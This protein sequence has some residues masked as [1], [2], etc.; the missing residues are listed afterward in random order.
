MEELPKIVNDRGHIVGEALKELRIKAQWTQATFEKKSGVSVRRL[1]DIENGKAPIQSAETIRAISDVVEARFPQLKEMGRQPVPSALF[2]NWHGWHWTRDRR[3]H[4]TVIPTVWTIDSAEICEV[5]RPLSKLLYRG[6]VLL[7]EH[8]RLVFT[9]D[10]SS[11]PQERTV[12]RFP[13][14]V[15]EPQELS[16][17]WFGIDYRRQMCCGR[18]VLSREKLTAAAAR[19][20]MAEIPDFVLPTKR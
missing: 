8:Q 5:N 6:S 11:D 4:P 15:D 9:L 2:K 12:W 14:T 20:R 18:A 3:G 17:A 13:Y 19:R 1:S 7:E 10:S 16:G